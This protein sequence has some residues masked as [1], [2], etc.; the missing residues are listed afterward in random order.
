MI[1]TNNSFDINYTS[2][3]EKDC[4]NTYFNL[5]NEYI[6][7]KSIFFSHNLEINE[8]DNKESNLFKDDENK[9][10]IIPYNDIKSKQTDLDEKQKINSIFKIDE[11]LF[12]EEDINLIMKKMNINKEKESSITLNSNDDYEEIKNIR[13]KLFLKK[14]R[15]KK[16]KND[17]MFKINSKRG[18]KIK[19]DNSNRIHNKYQ[20]DNIIQSIK[21][22]INHSLILFL[23]RLINSIYDKTQ[24]NQILS[25]LNL[26]RIQKDR[27]LKIFKIIKENDYDI[28]INNTSKS[29]NLKILNLTINNYI[30]NSISRRYKKIPSNYNKLIIKKLLNDEQNNDIFDFIFNYLK[31]ENW[32]D[33]F[34]YKKEIDNFIGNNRLNQIKINIL[35]KSLIRIDDCLLKMCKNNK[36]YFHCFSLMIY[37]FK[38]YFLKKEGRT[39]QNQTK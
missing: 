38:R 35:K 2:I 28:N 36:L 13:N 8:K 10:L 15:M 30:S 31:I 1:I 11:I 21:T 5:E 25:D 9:K 33:I 22:T 14:Y 39:L 37:N 18:R 20:P 6:D 3:D 19:N 24:I 7:S 23:N 12:Y 27:K 29:Y 16:Q 34:I 4:N 32:L 26:P 17:L